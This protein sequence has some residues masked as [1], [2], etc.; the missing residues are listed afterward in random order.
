MTSGIEQLLHKIGE[1]LKFLHFKLNNFLT[2]LK[3]AQ[4]LLQLVEKRSFN[5]RLKNYQNVEC[6]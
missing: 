1:N 5:S 4:N 6:S 3:A 2:Y